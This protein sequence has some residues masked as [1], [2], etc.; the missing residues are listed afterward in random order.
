[1]KRHFSYLIPKVEVRRCRHGKGVFCTNKIYQDEI[2]AVF[3]GYILT[4]EDVL[5]LPE[6]IKQFVMQVDEE[7]FIGPK[8]I[9]ELDDAEFIN[10]SCDPNLQVKGQITLIAKRDIL[11]GEEVTFDYASVDRH[12]VLGS[13]ECHCGASNCR[14]IITPYDYT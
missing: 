6:K 10:H 5:V 14:K 13:F 4:V 3:G 9:S 2:V 11:E 12:P 7:L 1:M 8:K